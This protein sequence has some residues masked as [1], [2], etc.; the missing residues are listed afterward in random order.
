[1]VACPALVCMPACVHASPMH[2]SPL[3]FFA[4][5]SVWMAWWRRPGGGRFSGA[6]SRQ[7]PRRRTHPPHL[8]DAQP[9]HGHRLA[10]D[11]VLDPHAVPRHDQLGGVVAHPAGPGGSGGRVGESHSV[12]REGG[13]LRARGVGGQSPTVRVR[14]GGALRARGVKGGESQGVWGREACC[15]PRGSGVGAPRCVE[16]RARAVQQNLGRLRPKFNTI[17]I[18]SQTIRAATLHYLG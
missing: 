3:A 18:K 4:L 11:D 16:V 1:M 2:A 14:E 10:R 5:R 17:S 7:Q 12:R 8:G 13:M 9:R 6:A 15:G